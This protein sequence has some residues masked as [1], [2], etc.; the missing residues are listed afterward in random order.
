[1]K[2]VVTGASGFVGQAVVREFL[3]RDVDVLGVCR[4]E[5]HSDLPLISI[6]DYLDTPVGDVLV[7]LAESRDFV[8]VQN[9]EEIFQQQALNTLKGLIEKGFGRIIYGSSSQVYGDKENYPRK[10]DELTSQKSVYAQTKLACE[11][12]ICETQ[13]VSVRMANLYG[14]GM[15]SNNVVSD[16]LRQISEDNPLQV[17]NDSPVRDFL[18]IEDAA[19]GLVDVALASCA[20][21]F[22]LGSGKGVSIGEL[23]REILSIAGQPHR[24]IQILQP[25]T[26]VSS[27]IL[28]ISLTTKITGWLPKVAL[29]E[30]LTYL[31]RKNYG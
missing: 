16:I 19:C 24:K 30:G 14:P 27:I 25:S 31:I 8:A 1:M 23:T 22:N 18:W 9:K 11:K 12:L 2:I 20:G 4:R 26:G 13:G 28:D 7:H 10:P 3:A 21:I 17:R 5:V 29:R 6:S 15:A